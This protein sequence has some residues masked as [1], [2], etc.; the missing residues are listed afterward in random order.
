MLPKTLSEAQA[1]RYN[2]WA[3]NSDGNRYQPDLCAA[4][5]P[6]G[7]RSMLFHQCYRKHVADG[8]YCKQHAAKAVPA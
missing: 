8:L 1:Y 7:G 2:Q 3:G 5:V 4:E 6:E